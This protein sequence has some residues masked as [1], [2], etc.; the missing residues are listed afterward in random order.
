MVTSSKKT[1]SK[2]KSAAKKKASSKKTAA[3]KVA[4]KKSAA[5]RAPRKRAPATKPDE[6]KRGRGRPTKFEESVTDRLIEYFTVE[7]P[8]RV[9][10]EREGKPILAP[11]EFPT[12]AGFAVKEGVDR[13]TLADWATKKDADGNLVYP[14][15]SGAY[16]RAKAAQEHLLV[17]GGLTG[18]YQGAF[19]IFTAKNVLG[20]RDQKDLQHS[21]GIKAVF[22]FDLGPEDEDE[23]EG[24]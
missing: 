15:F 19:A 3:K 16:K 10:G 4:S 24:P 12:L 21:G 6:P 1:A 9:V 20:W 2:K 13:D 11:V 23:D 14:D 22:G 7:S 5:K 17:Q 18:S 8:Y